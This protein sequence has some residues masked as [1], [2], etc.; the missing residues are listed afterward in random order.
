[1]DEHATPTDAEL[2]AEVD[3]HLAKTTVKFAD[4]KA[5]VAAG[6]YP[7]FGPPSEW[8][9]ARAA[10]RLIGQVAPP[11]PPPPHAGVVAIYDNDQNKAADWPAMSAVGATHLICGADDPQ[12]LA[13]LK[14]AGGHAWATV[15]YWNDSTG[16]FSHS[17]AEAQVIAR[18]AV[19]NYPGV[20]QGWYVA[21]EPS[22]AHA[23][24]PSLV[25]A[26]SKLLFD[27]LGVETIV[28][29]WDT[30]IFS[31]FKASC[32]AYAIDGYPNRDNW[33]LNDITSRAAAADQ[34]GIRYYGVLGAFTDG[35]VYKLPTAQNLKDMADAW[36]ATKQVGAA[37]YEWGPAG[38][39]T[40]TWL[41]NRPELL[42]VLKDEYGLST[43]RVLAE[44]DA[45]AAA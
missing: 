10:L 28:A 42:T 45:A 16:Q 39:P 32:T 27:I 20:I 38:G 41:Q 11:P 35:G 21:D 2:A 34:L 24:A 26:R 3:A 4:Y 22:L 37:I 8:G 6:K 43:V 18:Q 44:L 25:A 5:N 19:V 17:D 13:E 30:S 12:S 14:A 7:E 40:S 36:K 1:M 9:Q 31:R 23:A 33:N 29:M 15:G